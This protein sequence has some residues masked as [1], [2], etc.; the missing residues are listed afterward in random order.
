MGWQDLLQTKG[1]TLTSPWVGGRSLRSWSQV[2]HIEGKLPDEFG[3]FKFNLNGRKARCGS[4]VDQDTSVLRE[5]ITGYLVGDRIIPDGV[6]VDPDPSK[7]VDY[8]E[9]VYL[10]E[11]GLDRFVRVVV[12]RPFEDGPLVF[13][14]QTFPLGPEDEVQRAYLERAE[15][16]QG[17]KDVTP[18]LDAVFRLE[19]WQRAEAERRR[20]ELERKRKEEEERLAK[21]ARWRELTAKAGD[22]AGRREMAALDFNEAAKAAL[23]I[24]GATLLD[25]RNAYHRDEKVVRFRFMNRAFE[26]VCNRLTLG[27]IDA[28]ICLQ[29]HETGIKW[30]DVL[31]LESLPPVIREADN[32]GKLV[33]FRHV[34]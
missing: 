26:C 27:I 21:E 8:S 24:S 10:V 1:E 12:G 29:D 9:R 17:V 13:E 18:A 31:T 32:L 34:Y 11:P 5:K 28:G 19:T 3:W 2:W 4:P 25:V 30:D 22:G 7:I 14:T 33:V 23:A 16:V 15:S 20:A 6:R